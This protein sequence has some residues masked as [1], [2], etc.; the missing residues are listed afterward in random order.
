M[1]QDQF[2]S[3]QLWADEIE[4]VLSYAHAQ[5]KFDEYLGALRGNA[6]QRDSAIAE[7]RVAF[8]FHRNQHPVIQW[9]P[10]GADGNEGEYLIRAPGPENVFVEVKAPGWEGELSEQERKAGRAKQ[11][12][13]INAEARAIAPWE[14]I[15]FSIDKAYKKFLPATKN[16][17]VVADDLFVG[18]QHGTDLQ[19]SMALYSKHHD[20]RF[21]DRR[22]ER[23][24]G[25]G[26]FWVENDGKEIWYEMRLFLNPH[27]LASVALPETF[28]QAFHGI[29]SC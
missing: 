11:E 19:A 3:S 16:L 9:K 2:P 8:Y 1:T 29:A 20:G 10:I 28:V 18:L 22:C 26:L 24:G 17:L 23:L 7:L 12:K 25:V 15:Q 27:C 6:S 14:R 13:H 21:T 4:R 5:G